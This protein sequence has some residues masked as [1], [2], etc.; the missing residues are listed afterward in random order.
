LVLISEQK[1]FAYFDIAFYW[2][3][4]GV[5]RSISSWT[6]SSRKMCEMFEHEYSIKWFSGGGSMGK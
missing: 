6:Q 3:S 4:T 5:C 1:F 2:G